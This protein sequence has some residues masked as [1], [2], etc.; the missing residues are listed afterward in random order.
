MRRT[1]MKQ[2]VCL[3]ALAAMQSVPLALQASAQT[4]VDFRESIR[5]AEPAL[6]TVTVDPD[7]QV[8]DAEGPDLDEAD[9]QAAGDQAQERV[10]PQGPRFEFFDLNGRPIAPNERA[11]RRP[12]MQP[13]TVRSAGFAV[14]DSIVIAYIGSPAQTVSITNRHGDRFTGKVVSLD[15]VTGLAAIK[16]NEA[17]ESTLVVSAAETEPGMPVVAAWLDDVL[18]SDAGMI[19]SRPAATGS[20][21]GMSPSID[22]GSGDQMVGAPVLDASGIVVGVLVP[23]RNGGLVCARA[24]GVMRLIESATGDQ[25]QDLKR[26]LVGIQFEGG[27][28]LVLEVSPDSG[29]SAAGIKAGDMVK[30]VGEADVRDARQIVAAVANARAGDTVEIVVDRNGET[31]TIPVTL[32]EHPEQRIASNQRGGGM[33]GMNQ[34]FELKDGKLVPMEID[35]N[36]N[37][38]FRGF[39]GFPME[40]MFRGF[41]Q[42]DGMFRQGPNRLDGFRIERSDVEKTLKELQRQMEELNERLEDQPN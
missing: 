15:Y 33:M 20:G 1:M 23:S 28:P 2:V 9:N 19:A 11:R 35:P 41:P 26:G 29:A 37:P 17:P 5:T 16:V 32:T 22:F 27:G 38:M 34:A 8:V 4:L 36:A 24:A 25:P 7:D 39:G 14:D 13:Q 10:R 31:M 21:I 12:A 40:D 42:P 6:V 18:K 3:I 30:R